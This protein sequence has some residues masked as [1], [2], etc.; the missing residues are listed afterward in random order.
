MDLLLDNVPESFFNDV[1]LVLI[2]ESL[3]CF[4]SNI[5]FLLSSKTISSSEEGTNLSLMISQT[6]ST[7]TIPTQYPITILLPL[8]AY[9]GTAIAIAGACMDAEVK[10][11][12]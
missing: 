2:S 6:F 5:K 9:T 1:E 11:E 8:S 3:C 10:T 12:L 7:L 4:D